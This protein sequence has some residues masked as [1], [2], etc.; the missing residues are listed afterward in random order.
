M[1]RRMSRRMSRC[2]AALV[3]AAAAAASAA[4]G[5]LPATDSG[6]DGGGL[7]GRPRVQGR[8]VHLY[9]PPGQVAD[10]DSRRL[11]GMLESAV[12]EIAPRV[13]LEVE[14]PLTVALE[15][16]YTELARAVGRVAP[17]VAVGA[18]AGAAEI[19][20][21]W[22]PRDR[23]AYRVAVG[24]ALLHRAALDGAALEGAVDLEKAKP[25]WQR[26]AA[27]WLAGEWF[28]RPYEEWLPALAAADVMPSPADLLADEPT[29]DASGPLWTPVAAAVVAALGGE[30]AAA[31][32]ERAPSGFPGAA[33]TGVLLAEIARRAAA[34]PHPPA[35]AL[36]AASPP[37]ASP[38]P[39]PFL[40]GVSLAMLNRVDG[41]YHA[42]SLDAS[43]A[44]LSDLGADAV[45]LMPFAYQPDPRR[46]ELAFMNRHPASETDAGVVHAARRA[47]ERGL[48]VL[49]KPH[50]WISWES[51]PGE[52]EMESEEDWERWWRGYR[53]YVLHHAFLAAWTGSEV[54]SLGVELE[55]TV[56]RE[57]Q[58]RELAAA[59]RHLYPGAL[60]YAAN[61]YRGAEAVTFWDALDLIGVDAYYPL[62]DGPEASDEL[63]R[64][65]AERAVERL[66]ALA[67]KTGRPVILTEVG[68]AAARAPWTAP[69][70]EGGEVSEGDQARAYQALLSALGRPPWLRGAF[71][72]KAFSG[73]RRRGG[74]ADFAFLD[75]PAERAIGRW[76]RGGAGEEE[77]IPAAGETF[78]QR[79]PPDSPS[80]VRPPDGAA[81]GGDDMIRRSDPR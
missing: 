29:R 23:Y 8:G 73:P 33:G 42:P 54:L 57:R 80:S 6:A 56:G 3:V 2:W 21:V 1:S 22:H 78:L 64:R 66:A 44:R 60:T 12:A 13:P 45:A 41:G 18:T 81:G 49:W 48:R 50:L 14:R 63:L 27:L 43:L 52:V 34:R 35:A 77:G 32:L 30:T 76:L 15:R 59:A 26:G 4:A 9:L 71:F 74:R 28:G 53:R 40:A 68:F 65:G 46:P 47:R 69:H 36:P 10:P 39:V 17:A 70:S 24:Q 75:R 7:E 5:P 37:A 55:R 72:W 67:E 62:A 16:D 38:P 51:W 31:K 25:W 11:L 20:L 61:W 58:W 79:S 19:H